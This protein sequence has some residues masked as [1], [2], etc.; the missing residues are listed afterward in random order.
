[1]AY[2]TLIASLP[3]LPPHFDVDLPPI[4]R[5]RLNSR[6][7]QLT[8][9]DAA[10][11]KQLRDFLA[12]DRQPV[13]QTDARVVAHYA[14][15]QDEIKHPVLLEIVDHRINVRTIVSALRRRRDGQGPPEGVGKLVD[16]IRRNWQHPSFGL[17]H[18]FPWID[19][20][21]EQLQLQNAVEAER[22]LF[23]F[24]WT[25][26]CRM[27]SRFTFSFEAI[28]LYLARWTIVDRWTSRDAQ[29]GQQRFDRLI[30]ETLGEYANLQF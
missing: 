8:A 21:A 22:I 9:Q 19:S 20:F 17:Q 3:N 5:P 15:L 1:M 27:A 29:L 28:L 12:W 2:Y 11:L 4:T 7:R 10:T 25:T 23:E 14:R 13:D 24:T 18:A 26:W 30:E 6:L 16:R